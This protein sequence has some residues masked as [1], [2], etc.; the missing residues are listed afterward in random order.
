MY[1]LASSV[2]PSV[3]VCVCKICLFVFVCN[4]GE[5]GGKSHG[6]RQPGFNLMYAQ[7]QCQCQLVY[8]L[9]IHCSAHC[10]YTVGDPV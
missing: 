8:T 2:C 1:L 3:C 10:A 4:Q 5:Q 6:C 7:T 9:D